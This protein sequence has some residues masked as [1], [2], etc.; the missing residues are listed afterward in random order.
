MTIHSVS[1]DNI[2]CLCSLTI[3]AAYSN[4]QPNHTNIRDVIHPVLVLANILSFTRSDTLL[5]NT[6]TIH[7][8]SLDNIPCFCSST[9]TAASNITQP[10][11][12]KI[13]DVIHP[14]VV[15]ANISSF[16]HYNTLLLYTMTLHLVSLKNIPCLCSSTITAASNNTQLIHTNI[17]DVI[18][19]IVVPSNKL[20]FNHSNTLLLNTT[21]LHSVS[22]ENI[23][24]L[25]S[26]TIT[27]ASN[28][29]QPNH[30]NIP[31]VIHPVVVP[32]NLLSINRSDTLLLNNMTLH[33]VSLENIP[34][35][36][37]STISA[38]YNNTQPDHTNIPNVIHPIVVP[39]NISSFNRSDTLLLNTM[40]LNSVSLENI[41]CLCSATITAPYNNTQPNHTDVPN[42]NHPVVVPATISSFNSSNTLLL[43][44]MTLDSVSLKNMSCLCSS[45]ISAAYNSTQQNHTKIPDVIHPI[46]VSA[47]IKSFNH[48]NT[49]L[50]NTTKLHSVSLGNIPCLCSAT[51]TA[52]YNNT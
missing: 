45:T 34:C 24:C 50:L 15:P 19:P 52:A 23:P 2:P 8:V 26:A 32:A 35:L 9:I 18:H 3:T 44:T 28:N 43:N 38:A 48:S 37:S 7:S 25:R 46:V 4:T 1:L 29:T 36:R 31:D 6:M 10:N 39:A 16:N 5:L 33:M 22:L 30:T 14:V 20:Y 49:L 11:Q 12:T 27:A 17:P 13:S 42:V 51:I 41:P 21:T 40:T 47:N